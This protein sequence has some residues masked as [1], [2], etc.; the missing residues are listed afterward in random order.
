M[1]TV[2]L[3][4]RGQLEEL[5]STLEQLLDGGKCLSV[6]VAESDELLSPQAAATRLGF[7]RQ[8]VRR[9]VGAGELVGRQMPNSR[10]W[11]IPL[12]SVIAFERGREQAARTAD[13]FSAELDELGAPAE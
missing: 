5:T 2:N 4:S 13:T 3:T 11:K 1:K 6:T 10:Y 9:L 12:S 7:S 8:H